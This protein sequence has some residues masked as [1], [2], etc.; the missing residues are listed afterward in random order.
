MKND[1]QH[2]TSSENTTLKEL[3]KLA[4]DNV[5]YRKKGRIWIEGDHLISSAC[6]HGWM[7][8]I[9]VISSDLP[10]SKKE[11]LRLGEEKNIELE[12]EL[13]HKLSQLNSPAKVGAI[14]SIPV[15]SN[16][17]ASVPTI[18]L[19]RVQD[20]GNIGSILRSASA[21][22]F[23]QLIAMKGG[24]ALWAPKVV[25]S[26]M[27]A[28]FGLH[29]IEGVDISQLQCLSMPLAVTS[30]HHGA[31][32]R[33]TFFQTPMAWVFGHE[34]QGVCAELMA[35]ADFFIQIP[36]PGGEESLNIAAAA[37]ICLYASAPIDNKLS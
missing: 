5:Y 30:S 21:F 26:G 37:A 13:F 9:V 36:Q 29:L 7:P 27:G 35:R 4:N 2:I 6:H 22:G 14:F 12:P 33:Q 23:K 28:H 15:K 16:I 18:I 10:K 17:N 8:K 3:L 24:A 32:I 25:R 31:N 20:H 11:Q 1:W 34:G 19:D